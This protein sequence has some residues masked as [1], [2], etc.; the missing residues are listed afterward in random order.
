MVQETATNIAYILHSNVEMQ[1]SF[2]PE[3][4]TDHLLDRSLR[5]AE[6]VCVDMFFI[7]FPLTYYYYSSLM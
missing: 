3:L 7:A 4:K 1:H 2:R 5:E 6:S